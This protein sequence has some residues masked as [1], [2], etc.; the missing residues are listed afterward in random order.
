MGGQL[1]YKDR[2]ND[3]AVSVDSIKHVKHD[4]V[5]AERVKDLPGHH[6]NYFT[7]EESVEIIYNLINSEMK[8][9]ET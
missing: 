5:D 7:L 4:S 3:L 8:A 6:L 2:P 9:P 1:F